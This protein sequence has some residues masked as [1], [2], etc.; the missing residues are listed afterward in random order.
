[1]NTWQATCSSPKTIRV[2]KYWL[3]DNLPCQ[4]QSKL[5]FQK[6]NEEDANIRK[7]FLDMHASISSAPLTGTVHDFLASIIVLDQFSRNM[8]RNTK[9]SFASDE[10][11]LNLTKKL[12]ND[13]Y[14]MDGAT[15]AFGKW[16]WLFIILPFMHS[17]N[18]DDQNE[19]ISQFKALEK[20]FGEMDMLN[21]FAK[22]HQVIIERFGRFPHRN[23]ILGR[24]STPEEIKFLKEEPNSSF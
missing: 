9:L 13:G 22:Q 2:L 3:G 24:E 4:Q 11:A 1:M 14:L 15:S 18:I 6:S 12:C 10:L 19:C 20:R 8:F 7:Q 21:S 23:H 16:E 5:W 17:E